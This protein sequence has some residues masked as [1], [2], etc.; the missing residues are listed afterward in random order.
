[1]WRLF[2]KF[3]TANIIFGSKKYSRLRCLLRVKSLVFCFYLGWSG[4]ILQ[5]RQNIIKVGSKSWLLTC[6]S[7]IILS[8]PSYTGSAL[9]R[10][11]NFCNCY[12]SLLYFWFCPFQSEAL[13]YCK[14]VNSRL[15]HDVSAGRW[16]A[17]EIIH[18]L[19]WLYF[20]KMCEA[21]PGLVFP[22]SAFWHPWLSVTLGMRMCLETSMW[23]VITLGSWI[24]VDHLPQSELIIESSYLHP[25]YAN[26]CWM[27]I[28]WSLF[29]SLV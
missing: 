15:C 5:F 14:L 23:P 12:L 4:S 3:F 25:K 9:K 7:N 1:M 2:P 26:N 17:L 24:I 20:C 22:I 29:V 28:K 11:L 16:K 27:P 18:S 13:V 21:C 10:E 6:S 8:L 19:V